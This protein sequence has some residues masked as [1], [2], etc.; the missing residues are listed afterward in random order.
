[1]VK[2]DDNCISLAYVVCFSFGLAVS[3]FHHTFFFPF[4]F[5]QISLL[6][7]HMKLMGEYCN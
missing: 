7:F 3:G 6:P 5:F 2:D 4:F 1:M